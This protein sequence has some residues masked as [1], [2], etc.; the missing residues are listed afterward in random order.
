MNGGKLATNEM[1]WNG[2][3]FLKLPECQWPRADAFPASDSTEA[4]VIKNPV[5]ATH[6]LFSTTRAKVCLHEAVDCTRFS[7]FIKLLRVTAY[8]L[9]FIESLRRPQARHC[10][11]TVANVNA[12]QLTGEEMRTAERLWICS[13]QTESFASELS[14][15]KLQNKLGIPIRVSQF[16][17]FIYHFNLLRCRG[18]STTHN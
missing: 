6:V 12:N 5:A 10:D 14:Y 7:S 13:V 11:K 17:L 16:G 2:P 18:R 3:S 15:L 9:K 4:E 8:V 1:W